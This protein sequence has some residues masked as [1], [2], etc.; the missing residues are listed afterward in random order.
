MLINMVI[1]LIVVPLLVWIIRPRF[2]E[3]TELLVSEGIDLAALAEESSQKLRAKPSETNQN[4]KT[5][6][7]E[8][9]PAQP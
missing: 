8:V 9:A 2:I 7:V 6:L 1:A 4:L 3:S 5:E